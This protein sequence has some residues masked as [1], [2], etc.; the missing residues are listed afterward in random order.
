MVKSFPVFFFILGQQFNRFVVV[1]ITKY[2]NKSECDVG[3][4]S[5]KNSHLLNWTHFAFSNLV[6]S[7]LLSFL[8][9]FR[10]VQK[11]IVILTWMKF[12]GLSFVSLLPLVKQAIKS[13]RLSPWIWNEQMNMSS[14]GSPIC[15]MLDFICKMF[16]SFAFLFSI[17]FDFETKPFRER[18]GVYL[19]TEKL[20]NGQSMSSDSIVYKCKTCNKCNFC[21]WHFLRKRIFRFGLLKSHGNKNV[22]PRRNI[23]VRQDENI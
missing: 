7:Y 1:S 12:L 20:V 14:D 16:K 15:G 4:V 8:L 11:F 10:N 9:Q 3:V 13:T 21:I 22:Q 5:A 17:A 6:I 19:E 18:V 2:T 23:K